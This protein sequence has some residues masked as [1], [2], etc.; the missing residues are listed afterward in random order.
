MK[1]FTCKI[2]R[3][4][5]LLVLVLAL[6]IS[7]SL[8]V[9]TG[10]SEASE[11]TRREGVENAR[12]FANLKV[13]ISF[14]Q[15]RVNSSHT[16]FLEVFGISKEKK[17]ILVGVDLATGEIVRIVKLCPETAIGTKKVILS[18]EAIYD[19]IHEFLKEKNLLEIPDDYSLESARISSVGP[20]KQWELTWRH[21]VNDVKVAPDFIKFLLNPETGEVFTYSKVRHD[22]VV[23]TVPKIAR[24]EAVDLARATLGTGTLK[25]FDPKMKLIEVKLHIVYP[26]YYFKRWFWE[27]TEQQALSWIVTFGDPEAVIDVWVDARTGEIL[28]G[29]IYENPI[30][31]LY[32]IPNQQ[33]DITTI[34]E[35]ALDIMQYDTTHIWLTDVAETQVVNSIQNEFVFILQTHGAA[36]ATAERA[37]INHSGNFDQ[38]N[39][40]PDEVSTNDLRYALVSCCH[41]GDDGTGTDFKDVFIT[42]G[43]DVFQGYV[44]SIN[45]DPYETQ[46][47]RYLAEGRTLANAHNLAVAATSPSFTIVFTYNVGCINRVRLAPLLV[48]VTA[49]S[50]A[51]WPRTFKVSARV[52]NREDARGT[53]ASN[54]YAKL[55]VPP[56]FTITSGANP[57]ST[58]TLTHYSSWTATWTVR[59][60]RSTSPGT[61]TFDVEVWSCNLGVE[62]DDFDNPYHKFDVSV[63]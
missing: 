4:L 59:L 24:S 2:S 56:G 45:P 48:D 12:A 35:P 52:T 57:R 55:T 26:N 29:E 42:Q 15:P 22:V 38:D 41:S 32:G 19:K 14:T 58:G 39:L 18:R 63:P 49:P 31:E 11:I 6:L 8:E 40:T 61:Y 36:T 1:K 51:S 54:V 28:G 10:S 47:V 50:S 9:V 34:W 13:V 7:G 5:V 16:E 44:G 20:W 21:V 33:G 60:N 46:L 37:I 3:I 17:R 27:W 43:A 23:P 25:E 30:P 62:V 53:T